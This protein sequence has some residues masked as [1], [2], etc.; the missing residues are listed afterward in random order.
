[1]GVRFVELKG[2]NKFMNKD[3][4]IAN[5]KAKIQHLEAEI[6]DLI[7]YKHTVQILSRWEV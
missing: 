2:L 4:E 3:Q 6:D 7:E 5:L 1:M